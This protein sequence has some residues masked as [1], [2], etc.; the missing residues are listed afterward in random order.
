VAVV[1]WLVFSSAGAIAC[2]A[3]GAVWALVSRGSLNSRR[4]LAL[5]AVFYWLAGSYIVPETVRGL[6]ARG[7]APL[8]RADVPAGRTAVVLLGSGSHQFRDWTDGQFVVVDRIAA[9]RLL[10]AARVY[11]LLDADFI[12]S[13]GG[14]I[15]P[16]P[17]T[18]PSGLA[19]AEDLV[20]LG[21]PRDRIIVE[22]ESMTT[23]HEA[24]LVKELLRTHPVDH[25]VLVTSQF[26]MLRSV[27]TFRAAGV[28][29]IPA[30]AREPQGVDEWWEKLIPTDKG[31]D[32]SG[33]A[34][35]ELAGIV[36][37]AVRGWYRGRP[38]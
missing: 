6:L 12:V 15:R 32:E 7:Y 16:T 14:L 33:M 4:F 3:L 24:V 30:I 35:H 11:R 17:R 2:L 29:V 28:E 26:H 27:G 8:T 5:C 19:M 9:S 23:R 34:A 37:Y 22:A 36:A 13:S 10:E 1:G 25:V 21:V 18:W 38:L 20:R 31:M